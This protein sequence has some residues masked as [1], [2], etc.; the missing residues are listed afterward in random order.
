M[1]DYPLQLADIMAMRNT[2]DDPVKD[3]N[4][5]IGVLSSSDSGLGVPPETD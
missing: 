3:F 1:A 5:G 2:N 4:D